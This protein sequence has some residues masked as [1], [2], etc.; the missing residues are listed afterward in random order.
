MS[1]VIKCGRDEG[2][3]SYRES[4]MVAA[5]PSSTLLAGAPA[6]A[7]LAVAVQ[8]VRGS[9]GRATWPR[10]STISAAEDHGPRSPASVN[11][12]RRT[13]RADSGWKATVFSTAV[14]AH[15]PADTGAE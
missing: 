1:T 3:S 15:V 9:S 7:S 13:Y 14:S 10:T 6:A 4:H 8:P 2:V 5:S 12:V 11:A